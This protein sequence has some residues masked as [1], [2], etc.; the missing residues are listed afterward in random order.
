[1]TPNFIFRLAYLVQ[2]VLLKFEIDVIAKIIW[3]HAAVERYDPIYPP[4]L[5]Q[6]IDELIYIYCVNDR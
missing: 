5:K 1:M 4:S 2:Y 3:L 6:M